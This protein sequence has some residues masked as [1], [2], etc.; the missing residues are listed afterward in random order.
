MAENPVDYNY[1]PRS[2]AIGDFNDDSWPDIVVA[3][4]IMNMIIIYLGHSNDGFLNRFNYST[5]LDSAPHMVAVGD[6]N[7]D[8]RLDIAVANF[9]TNNV[10]IFYGLGNR[11]VESQIELSTTSSRPIAVYL[12]DLNKDT[13]LDIVTVNNGTHSVSIFYGYGDRRFL[14]SITYS[15]GYDTFPSSLIAG[16][17]NNDNYLDLV[18]ANYGTNDVGLLFG[19][20]NSTFTNEVI[21]TTSFS[22]HL[23]SVTCGYF[24]DDAFLD[25]AVACSGTNKISIFLNNANGTFTNRT[26]YSINPYSPYAIGVGDFNSDNRLDLIVTNKGTN[27]IG[28]L[29]GYGNGTFMNP[30]MYSTGSI[31]SIAFDVGDLNKDNRLDLVVVNNDTGA[32]DI[33]FGHFEGFSNQTFHSKG[34]QPSSVAIGDFNNDT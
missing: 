11:S 2:V 12:V 18:I 30:N 13:L 28:V 6:L 3:N 23:S 15:A 27:N 31:S 24:N 14:N 26:F 9:G 25:I 32:I 34:M 1:G 33:L 20:R 17:F 19:N 4:K 16:D 5:G 7:R 21:L 8:S 10:G 29:M 22:S